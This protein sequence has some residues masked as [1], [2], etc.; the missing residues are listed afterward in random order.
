MD[1]ENDQPIANGEESDK[2]SY[3]IEAIL[4]CRFDDQ[5][6][7]EY[8]L[9]WE[10]YSE[11]DN[12][13]EPEQNVDAEGMVE[14]FERERA[15]KEAKKE[16]EKA[17]ANK[18]KEK[19]VA[20]KPAMRRKRG[21]RSKKGKEAPKRRKADVKPKGRKVIAEAKEGKAN[22]V[23]KIEQN[24]KK[25]I[26]SAENTES[27]ESD[28]EFEVEKILKMR[29]VKGKKEYYLKWKGFPD[30]ENTWEPEENMNA[31]DLLA[32]FKMEGEK[33][34]NKKS[35]AK[36]KSGTTKNVEAKTGNKKIAAKT[37]KVADKAKDKEVEYQA[38]TRK[39]K[40]FT[41]ENICDERIENGKTEYYLKWKGFPE[42]ENT[43]EPAENVDAADMVA[44]FRKKKETEKAKKGK[45][46]VGAKNGKENEGK[47]IKEET[48][49]RSSRRSLG[50]TNGTDDEQEPTPDHKNTRKSSSEKKHTPVAKK[51][52]GGNSRSRIR[53]S[54]NST[55][56]GRLLYVDEATTTEDEEVEVDET[57]R[58]R[59]RVKAN[60]KASKSST[61]ESKKT[62]SRTTPRG[63]ARGS[64][65]GTDEGKKTPNGNA[66]RGSPRGLNSSADGQGASHGRATTRNKSGGSLARA[67][68]KKSRKEK[69]KKLKKTSKRVSMTTVNYLFKCFFHQLENITNVNCISKM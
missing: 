34:K 35:Q 59:S 19:V 52:A 27:T 5:G 63:K 18:E 62:P 36:A 29:T 32:D 7:K 31:A 46:E 14:E 69:N 49:G 38:P 65:S 43:W 47:K 48:K 9:K 8:L 45:V 12:T 2:D 37:E 68:K 64:L 40:E 24:G 16:K 15:E 30:S 41:V 6:K 55:G 54:L 67:P 50:E 4:D 42:S 23:V 17:E 57:T 26:E 60:P 44:A 33:S 25:K 13:W 10:N 28:E 53:G 22:A 66:R 61:D 21:S 56:E 51:S 20:K 3:V 58:G 1:S 11:S 39:P